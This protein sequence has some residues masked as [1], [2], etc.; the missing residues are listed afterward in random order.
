MNSSENAQTG[1][2]IL[3]LNAVQRDSWRYDVDLFRIIS[4]AG[5]VWYHSGVVVGHE[6]SYAGLVF[7]IVLSVYFGGYANNKKK[8]FAD[9]VRR[10]LVPWLF[11]GA[12]YAASN[13]VL[14]KPIFICQDSDV[15]AC[16]LVGSSLH[17]WYLPFMFVVLLALDHL[18]MYTHIL[19]FSCVGA[20]LATLMLTSFS[21]WREQSLELGA[22][23][24]QH[25]HAL[26]GVFVGMFFCGLGAMQKKARVVGLS[27]LLTSAAVAVP[28]AGLGLPYIVGILT[29]AVCLLT[30]FSNYFFSRE[31]GEVIF[32]LAQCTFG[33]YLVHPFFLAAARKFGFLDGAIPPVIAFFLSFLAIYMFR[34]FLPRFAVRVT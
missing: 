20:V 17:L 33:V 2:P 34:R 31:Q 4:A 15:I 18:R 22:P 10:L 26:A 29:A 16:L 19:V 1:V 5:I 23:W 7:F 24:A 30:S 27:V 28:A 21:L 6:F 32:G 11:W 14:R 12:L 25:L 3:A 9:R 13:F 8:A